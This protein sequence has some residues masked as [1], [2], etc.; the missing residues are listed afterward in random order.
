MSSS[1][2]SV[3]PG[4]GSEAFWLFTVCPPA[5][6]TADLNVGGEGLGVYILR[7]R[8]GTGPLTAAAAAS[9]LA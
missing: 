5:L 9:G 3:E 8:G 6:P 7:W 2:I 4:P 1:G